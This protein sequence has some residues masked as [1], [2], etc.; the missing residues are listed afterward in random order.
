MSLISRY[1]RWLHLRWPAGTV[2]RLPEVGPDYRSNVP[3]LYI[4]G[5]LTGVPL[6]KFSAHSGAMAIQDIVADGGFQRDR[7]SELLDVVIIGAGVSGMSA[8]R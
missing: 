1:S 7:Q 4:V 3:G 6:L 2:E 5:D 8:A